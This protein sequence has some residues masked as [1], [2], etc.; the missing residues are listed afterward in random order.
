MWGGHADC[1]GSSKTTFADD[2]IL[3][4]GSPTEYI[5]NFT[6]ELLGA[7]DFSLGHDLMV[8][9][10]ELLI[11]LAV[12]SAEPTSDLL[13]SL[14]SSPTSECYLSLKNK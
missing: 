3:Y 9:E 10:S 13:F 5:K 4:L 1:K 11:G 14:C 8:Y 2:K 6:L 12:V 7:P